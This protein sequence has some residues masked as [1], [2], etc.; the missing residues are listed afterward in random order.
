MARPTVIQD[1]ML[2]EAAR[3]V[4]LERGLAATTAE[5]AARAG[6]SEGT[7]FKRFGSKAKLF[8]AAMT[9]ESDVE[10]LVAQVAYGAAGRPAEEVL[11][12][13][14]AAILAK[15]ERIVP[16]IV[17]HISGTLVGEHFPPFMRSS[18]PPVRLLQAVEALLSS[19]VA[20]GKL[21]KV[22]VAVVSRTLVGSLFQYVFLDYVVA[23]ASGTRAHTIDGPTYAAG[24]VKLV[25]FGA[26]SPASSPARR[27]RAGRPDLPAPPTKKPSKRAKTRRQ[28][29][30]S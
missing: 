25:L 9:A 22:D 15:F 12:T 10:A 6:V 3:A 21:A 23:R 20:D 13:L 24:L 17:T 1:G 16:M 11:G 4:F 2:L 26:A 5:V 18:P 27:P 19:L 30:H 28:G 8:E 14:A 29:G 7:L